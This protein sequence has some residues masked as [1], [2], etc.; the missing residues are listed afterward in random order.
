MSINSLSCIQS[1]STK[2]NKNAPPP[3]PIN[4]TDL[5]APGPFNPFF[6]LSATNPT[7]SRNNVLIAC[8]CVINNQTA[9][10]TFCNGNYYISTSCLTTEDAG[11]GD[12]VFAFCGDGPGVMLSKYAYNSSGGYTGNVSTTVSGSNITGEWMQII[13]PYKLWVTTYNIMT[14][15]ATGGGGSWNAMFPK[16]FTLAGSNNGTTWTL[17]DSRTGYTS[18]NNG[19]NYFTAP[20]QTQGFTYFRLIGSAT[21]SSNTFLRMGCSVG[22]QGQY[23]FGL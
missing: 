11:G 22:L 8:T 14:G 20:I 16:N 18:S 17:I 23:K 4:I 19:Y 10:Y 13:L 6:Y 7:Y 1:I 21:A 3:P 9:P 5:R 2:C 12:L 15:A